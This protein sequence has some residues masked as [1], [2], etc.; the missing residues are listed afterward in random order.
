MN[1]PVSY[2][3]MDNA[4]TSS[5]TLPDPWAIGDDYLYP[6]FPVPQGTYPDTISGYPTAGAYVPD[7]SAADDAAFSLAPT[8]EMGAFAN[9][10]PQADFT[11]FVNQVSS[12][13]VGTLTW[14]Y[15]S[16]PQDSV[17]PWSICMI[18]YCVFHDPSYS[19]DANPKPT[20]ARTRR[21]LIRNWSATSITLGLLLP[22]PP[23]QRLQ[24]RT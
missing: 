18:L 23:T 9:L 4:Q 19:P 10:P 6:N 7:L 16:V 5:M 17:D 21:S 1:Y 20:T 11:N 15:R 8:T 24:H 12:Q 13:C 2:S 3:N 14:T 22:L